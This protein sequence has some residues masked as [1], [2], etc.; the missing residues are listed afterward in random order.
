MKKSNEQEFRK[1]DVGRP[2]KAPCCLRNNAYKGWEPARGEE[3]VARDVCVAPKERSSWF[4]QV[5]LLLF[6]RSWAR[7][8]WRAK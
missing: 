8:D 6:H 7:W 1:R 5:R 4:S 2:S 3:S